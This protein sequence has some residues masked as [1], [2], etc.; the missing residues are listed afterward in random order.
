MLPNYYAV[1]QGGLANEVALLSGQGPTPQTAA[2]CPEYTRDR[3]GHG[4]RRRAGGRQRLRLPGETQTLPGQ[5]AESKLTWKAYVE[6]IGNGARPASRPAAATRPGLPDSSQAPVAGDAYETWRNPF[7]Y[8]LGLTE[9]PECAE[10]RCR[11]RPAG[12][13]PEDAEEDAD[14]SPTSSPTPATTAA[15]LPARPNSPPASAAAGLPRNGR[16]EDHRLAGLQGRRPD[17]DHLRRGAA[18]RAEPPTPAPVAPP[19]NTRTC[20]PA[21]TTAE[22]TT[23]G[24][25]PTGGGGKVGLL[26]ISPYVKARQRQRN[27]LLQPLLAAAQHRGTASAWSR[28]DTPPAPAL[29]VFGETVYNAPTEKPAETAAQRAVLSLFSRAG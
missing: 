18:G 27:R 17:R 14:A 1:T 23:G 7:V 26:L 29:T 2:N 4:R 25:K 10:G 21:P 9:S 6:D 22:V 11:P 19:P 12:R 20:R 13:R 24:V 5:L 15:K 3:T 8:F 28:S 16:A